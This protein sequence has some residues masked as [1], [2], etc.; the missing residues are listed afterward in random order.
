LHDNKELSVTTL[1][2]IQEIENLKDEW[3]HLFASRKE[4]LFFQTYEW[5]TSWWK[6]YGAKSTLNISFVL[7]RDSSDQLLLL[8]PLVIDRR[9][10]LKVGVWPC[11]GYGQYSDVLIADDAQPLA[12]IEVA[13]QR[14]KDLKLDLMFL[15]RVRE[16]AQIYPFLVDQMEINPTGALTCVA[17]FDEMA[18]WDL[19]WNSLDRK[20]KKRQKRMLRQFSSIGDL[21]FAVVSDPVTIP[22]TLHELIRLKSEWFKA[23]GSYGRILE[24]KKAADWLIDIALR[25]NE[26]DHLNLTTMTLDGHL[27]AGQLAFINGPELHAHLGVYDIQHRKYGVGRLQT[28]DAMKWAIENGYKIFDFMPPEDTYKTYWTNNTLAVQSFLS[29]NTL[30]GSIGKYFFRESVREKIKACY[31]RLPRRLRKIIC[32]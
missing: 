14:I 15:D 22:Q 25:A 3:Q 20:F 31:E 6:F 29:T 1:C 27:V 5:F 4:N 12:C 24:Q 11:Q 32:A 26:S 28:E 19:F 30:K 9:F 17:E 10:Q 8:W 2:S 13:W 21:K 18:S 23:T 16:D 7:V